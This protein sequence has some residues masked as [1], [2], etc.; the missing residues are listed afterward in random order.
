MRSN[1]SLIHIKERKEGIKHRIE[2]HTVKDI[3]LFQGQHTLKLNQS[4]IQKEMVKDI[5]DC[6]SNISKIK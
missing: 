1:S 4:Q 6:S 3:Q 2:L 5:I